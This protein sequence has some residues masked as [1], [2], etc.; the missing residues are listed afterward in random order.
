M[1]IIILMTLMLSAVTAV[2]QT[3]ELQLARR[4]P[5]ELIL[6]LKP[7]STNWVTLE[8][9]SD[10]TAWDTS[11]ELF[12]TNDMYFYESSADA[13]NSARCFYRVRRPGR[14]ATAE[15]LERW[16]SSK[17]GSY[18]YTFADTTSTRILW[19]TVIV[20]EG[21]KTVTNSYVHVFSTTTTNSN[22]SLVL[23][24]DDLFDL[25]SDVQ[26]RGV[27]QAKLTYDETWGFPSKIYLMQWPVQESWISI[28]DFKKLPDKK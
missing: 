14:T 5:A 24:V 19:G 3:P 1:K 27:V 7:S 6:I 10:L 28:R 18:S 16:E 13:T 20:T 23:S 15:A 26:T 12:T 21:V 9:S 2:G 17:P 22:P 8:T 11:L 4:S 25:L